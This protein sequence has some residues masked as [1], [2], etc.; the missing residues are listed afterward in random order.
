MR[1]IL[2]L[3]LFLCISSVSSAQ[4]TPQETTMFG[5]CMIEITSATEMAALE[6]EMRSNPYVKVVRLDYNSQRAFLLTKG[7]DQ[8]TEDQFISWFNAY[9][10]KVRCIQVGTY[11]VDA[12]KPFPFE[13]C[14]K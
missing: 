1:N 14:D 5:Q 13:G 12:L 8:L 7:I 9:G 2:V 11:G 6:T 10:D 4:S 3:L